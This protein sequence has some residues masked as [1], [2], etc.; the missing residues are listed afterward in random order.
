MT[1]LPAM[2]LRQ[3]ITER[4]DPI[5][6]AAPS[7]RL[8]RSDYDLNPGMAPDHAEPLV[9]AAVLAGLVERPDGT[10][11]L[12]TRRT[13]SLRRHAGQVALP[14]GRIDPGET[15][16]QAALREAREE[17]DL[18]PSHVEPMGISTAYQTGTGYLV[19]PIVA[20]VSPR[21]A[22]RPNPDEV[23]AIFE[24][25]FEYLMNPAHHEQRSYVTAEG[26]TRHYYAIHWR[27]QLIWG[28]TAGM[29]RA[30]HDRLYGPGES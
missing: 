25:P 1:S 2:T 19:T 13:D 20:F 26:H 22:L 9:A 14:G 27:D 10:T 7:A 3:L 16:L 24:A 21:M 29:V 30:L 15:P 11:L 28:A 4:L 23:A 6:T 8:P 18:D 17:I 5:E 12:L